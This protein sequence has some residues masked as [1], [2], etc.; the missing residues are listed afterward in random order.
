MEPLTFWPPPPEELWRLRLRVILITAPIAVLVVGGFVA[1]RLMTTN[2]SLDRHLEV[3]LAMGAGFVVTAAVLWLVAARLLL[4]QGSQMLGDARA[5][6]EVAVDERL[7]VL[8]Q[9]SFLER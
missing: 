6:V 3:T 7:L 1:V 4:A 8:C 5:A 2:V 9:A